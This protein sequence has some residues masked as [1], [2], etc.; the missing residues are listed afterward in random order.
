M[1]GIIGATGSIGK[2]CADIL[3]NYKRIPIK[4]GSRSLNHID[5]NDK[6]SCEA[7]VSDC[8]CVINCTAMKD[9]SIRNLV[10][11]LRLTKC[12]LIDVNE[13]D[14][15]SAITNAATEIYIG[16]GASPGLT[17]ALPVLLAE[18][19]QEITDLEVYYMS[20]GKFSFLA[21]K[22]YLLYLKKKSVYASAKLENGA[23][24]SCG[25]RIDYGNFRFENEDWLRLPYMDDRAL[26]VCKQ[27]KVPNAKF[28]ICM[29]DGYV[30]ETVNCIRHSND[31]VD[32]LAD[33]LVKASV[34]DRSIHKDFSGFYV[35]VKGLKGDLNTEVHLIIKSPSPE[36]LTALTA[37]S[38]AVLSADHHCGFSVYNMQ[39]IPFIRSLPHTM[40]QLDSKFYYEIFEGNQIDVSNAYSGE[41]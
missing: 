10:E 27:I 33:R 38:V 21:A 28:Y 3:E 31:P 29:K 34:L 30:Y 32:L 23:L 15:L 22:E 6:K 25:S 8:Q 17:E 41:I 36:R 1:I 2:E 37:S 19:F 12:K 39:N 4:K 13:N 11:A 7:F 18:D 5:L 9:S 40:L 24:V 20:S 26:A 14:V 35:K 16:A